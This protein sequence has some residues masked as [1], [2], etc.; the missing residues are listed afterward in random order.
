MSLETGFSVRLPPALR[1]RLAA[2]SARSALKQ[3]DLVRMAVESYVSDAERTGQI[4]IPVFDAPGT[5][6]TETRREATYTKPKRA[7][8]KPA[9][10]ENAD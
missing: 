9:A 7:P 10:P 6:V 4:A 1:E 2:V 5:P 3:S 8:K